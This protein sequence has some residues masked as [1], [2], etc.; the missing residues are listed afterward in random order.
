MD[1]GHGG[2]SSPLPSAQGNHPELNAWRVW[3][4]LGGRR[5]WEPLNFFFFFWRGAGC[6]ATRET[7]SP[8]NAFFWGVALLVFTRQVG[9]SVAASYISL[10][11][12]CSATRSFRLVLLRACRERGVCREEWQRSC[13][14]PCAR[15][16]C[17]GS[18]KVRWR[19]WRDGGPHLGAPGCGQEE[20]GSAQQEGD[21]AEPHGHRA[22][23]EMAEGAALAVAV[24]AGPCL[25]PQPLVPTPACPPCL[26][27][28]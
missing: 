27:P 1:L 10:A 20:E 8:R 3:V 7:Y 25:H 4:I 11:K 17:W 24:L 15:S 18:G 5:S 21:T 22:G 13:V 16:S 9:G 12:S 14:S 26:P 6:K 19:V 2:C 23:R 28:P